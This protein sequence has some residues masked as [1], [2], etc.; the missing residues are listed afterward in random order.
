MV[1]RGVI[2]G[3]LV[4]KQGGLR[5]VILSAPS[6][7]ETALV[8]AALLVLCLIGLALYAAVVLAD[9]AYGRGVRASG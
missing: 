1:P 8:F 5:Y 4:I 9:A 3:A 6:T 2:I 7:G